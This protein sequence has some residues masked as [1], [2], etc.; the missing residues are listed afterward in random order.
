MRNSRRGAFGYIIMILAFILLA[1]IISDSMS[2]PA[3]RIS[4]PQLLEKIKN[5]DVERVSIRGNRLVGRN[6]ISIIALRDYPER[7]DFE[8][9]I[10]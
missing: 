2:V 7:F 1:V 8:T 10:G 3:N 4:Y 5:E 6:K 9:T